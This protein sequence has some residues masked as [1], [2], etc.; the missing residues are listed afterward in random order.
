M[1]GE[2]SLEKA[3]E[4]GEKNTIRNDTM[5][6]SPSQVIRIGL[7][8]E[9]NLSHHKELVALLREGETLEDLRRLTPEE[10]LLRWV[11]YHL[12]RAG[13]QREITNFKDDIMDSEIY[14]NLLQQ[15]TPTHQ[16]AELIPVNSVLGSADR[17]QRAQRV[18]QNSAVLEADLFVLPEDIAFASEKGSNRDKLNLA[19]VANL[20]NNYPALEAET[21]R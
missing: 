15:I 13:V 5:S 19:F 9:V 11:N 6:S 2:A 16:Q 7:L 3:E 1:A 20:F 17:V 18:L 4:E 12:A 10:L 8:S 14:A 21:G